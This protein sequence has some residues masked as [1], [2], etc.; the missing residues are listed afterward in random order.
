MNGC[1]YRV[2]AA[3]AASLRDR[4]A[5]HACHSLCLFT[6]SLL[7][8]ILFLVLSSVPV[9]ASI[10]IMEVR[11]RKGGFMTGSL[12]QTHDVRAP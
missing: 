1:S 7:L 3:A 6:A 4:G 5:V 8:S 11:K 2:Q 12:M 9:R 10:Y